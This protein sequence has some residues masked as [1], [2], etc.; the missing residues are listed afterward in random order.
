MTK[1]QISQ[2]NNAPE[3]VISDWLNTPEPIT[4]GALRGK[5]VVIEAFQML[6]PGCVSHGLPQASRIRQTFSPEDVVVLG[7]H[8]VFEH[9]EVQGSK[10]A[11]Q[12]FVH[13]YSLD[14]PIGID[15]PAANS[16]LPMSMQNFSLRGTPSLILINREGEVH[17]QLF[18]TVPD[19]A[20]GASLMEL[21]LRIP[22][23]AATRDT[24]PVSIT[25]SGT[26]SC[27][28]DD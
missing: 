2:P 19:L 27:S 6:C 10:A 11:L 16:P 17:N 5:V 18:G 23:E 20:L 25:P 21:V 4:L 15:A 14:F 26:P 22:A 9:H 12:A 1:E 13:E 24:L 3:L 28:T 7:L 8:S